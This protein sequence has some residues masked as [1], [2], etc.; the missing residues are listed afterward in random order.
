MTKDT[1]TTPNPPSREAAG[2]VMYRETL[3]EGCVVHCGGIPVTLLATV[4]V[5]SATR[6]ELRLSD[7]I[8]VH[9]VAAPNVPPQRPP[10]KD[11]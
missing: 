5:E 2:S 8:G 1:N 11:V 10:A 6:I 7:G 4:E 9:A 3:P